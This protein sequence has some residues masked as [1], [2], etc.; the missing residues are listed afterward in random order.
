LRPKALQATL[1]S[2]AAIDR[3]GQSLAGRLIAGNLR[4]YSG[5]LSV[6]LTS[7]GKPLQPTAA[8]GFQISRAAPLAIDVT[9]GPKPVAG[10]VTDA[11]AISDG[12][13]VPIVDFILIVSIED[14]DASPH[15]TQRSP[16]SVAAGGPSGRVGVAA[17]APTDP[18]D[19][20]L[21]VEVLQQNRL[22]RVLS[23]PIHV[24]AAATDG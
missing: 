15:F 18:G 14:L 22:V 7:A 5:I 3:I 24:I 17:T 6:G 19:Y 13:D 9:L 21:M 16:V 20:Q 2:Q 10:A 1:T 23:A 4:N 8:G 12:M 11:I